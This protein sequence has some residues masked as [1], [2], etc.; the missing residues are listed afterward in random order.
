MCGVDGDGGIVGA[1]VSANRGSF[2]DSVRGPKGDQGHP[3]KPGPQGTPGQPG[4]RG[5]I[6]PPGKSSSVVGTASAA[7]PTSCFE[8]RQ[9]GQTASGIYSIKPSKLSSTSEVFCDMDSAGGG[10]TL[11]ASIHENNINGKCTLGDNWSSDQGL[12]SVNATSSISESSSWS[13]Y[14]VFGDASAATS[15]DFKSA[16]YFN[17][18]ASDVMVWH[19]P[20][21]IPAS[22][23]SSQATLKY[24]T[25]NQFLSNYGGTLQTLFK[26]YV[27]MTLKSAG[28]PSSLKG[29]AAV[30][31]SLNETAQSQLR[32]IISDFYRYNYDFSGGRW[33]HIGDGGNDMFDNGNRVFYKVG[34]SDY[35]FMNYGQ[36]YRH[37][38]EQVEVATKTGYPF[39]ALMWIGNHARSVDSFQIKVEDGTGADNSGNSHTND[40]VIVSNGM[41]CN[42]K[43]YSVFGAGDPAIC[44][45]FFYMS[46]ATR[47]GSVDP[48]TFDFPDW[49]SGQT[50][51]LVHTARVR[52]SPEGIMLGYTL[53]SRSS[54]SAVTD[55]MVRGVL[56]A[57]MGTL[58]RFTDIADFNCSSSNDS[59]VAPVSYVVG[60]NEQV[61]DGIPPDQKEQ[62]APGFIQFGAYDEFGVPN[63][64][65]P[66]VRSDACRPSSV[67]VGGVNTRNAGDSSACGDFTGWGGLK[68]D[69]VSA[70]TPFGSARSAADINSS[71]LLF[72]RAARVE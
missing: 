43:Y 5:P 36:Y 13:N 39:A 15:A 68:K 72:T 17:L 33:N 20:N 60:S 30:A 19:V 40:G 14:N 64:L 61:M 48:D 37:S 65:C 35:Q 53:L 66:G 71:I 59:V 45:V 47:W 21:D 50:D 23:W 7:V 67:C 9:A 44:K 49:T 4:L 6:G 32:S 16:A 69:H 56:T 1:G 34:S 27:P 54:G 41:T 51:N 63:A 29:L 2:L 52:G 70:T 12:G 28:E 57:A 3:G 42:Y 24:Y 25:N 58:D 46:S 62:V 26:K 22:E 11:V 8:M 38:A 18:P 55:E 10:W 31:R